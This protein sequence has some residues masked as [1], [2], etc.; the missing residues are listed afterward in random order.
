M[1]EPGHWQGNNLIE[2]KKDCRKCRRTMALRA[3]MNN[4]QEGVRIVRGGVFVPGIALQG[5]DNPAGGHWV[6]LSRTLS[7]GGDDTDF[8][9]E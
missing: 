8:T 1:P 7:L 6:A 9:A 5:A 4:T 3:N 2:V